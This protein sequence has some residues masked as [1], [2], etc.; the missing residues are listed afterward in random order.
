MDMCMNISVC[1]LVYVCV[2]ERERERE[3]EC[4]PAC[5]CVG[6]CVCPHVC[7]CVCVCV[8][9]CVCLRVRVRVRVCVYVCTSVKGNRETLC[10][11][12][13][14]LSLLLFRACSVN[15]VFAFHFSHSLSPYPDT[16]P[17]FPSLPQYVSLLISRP[18]SFFHSLTRHSQVQ[19]QRMKEKHF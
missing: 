16:L 10:L 13:R 14:V 4:V 7:A 12:E 17:P 19:T 3:T 1:V 15:T 5:W 8:F 9:V 18:P 2:S 6:V 11:W